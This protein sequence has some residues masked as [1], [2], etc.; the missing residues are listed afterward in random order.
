MQGEMAKLAGSRQQFIQQVNENGMVKQVRVVAR[1]YQSSLAQSPIPQE[2]D[3]L[4]ADGNVFKLI[5]PVLVKQDLEDA[6]SNV[7][8]RLEFIKKEL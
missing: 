2:L 3:L 7:E 5:G 8:K 1:L 4:D 6:K